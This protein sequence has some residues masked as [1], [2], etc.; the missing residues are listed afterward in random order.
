MNGDF[1]AAAVVILIGACFLGMAFYILDSGGL[2]QDDSLDMEYEDYRPVTKPILGTNGPI[3]LVT[4]DGTEYIHA[5]GLGSCTVLYQG[6][7]KDTFTV[8][9]AAAN[10]ILMCGQSNAAYHAANPSA[11]LAPAIGT[12]F[13][14]GNEDGMSET[15]ADDVSNFKFYDFIDCEGALRVGDKGPAFAAT[16]YQETGHKAIWIS[17]GMSGRAVSFWN[18]GAAAWNKDLEIMTLANQLLPE[19]FDITGTYLFWSQGETDYAY[20]TGMQHYISTWTSFHDRAP[21]AWGRDIDH[22]YLAMGRYE[23]CGWVNDAFETLASTLDDVSIG[24]AIAE[25]FTIDNTLLRGDSLHYS[26]QGDNALAVSLARSCASDQ[27]YS[28]TSAP[29]YLMETIIRC[30]VNDTV[31]LDDVVSCRTVDNRTLKL[32][33]EWAS[34]PVTTTAGIYKITGTTDSTMMI[35]GTPSPIAMLYVGYIGYVDG[36]E[37]CLNADGGASVIGRQY[38]LENAIIPETVEGVNVTE[39]G[40]FALYRGPFLKISIPDTVTTLG[41]RSLHSTPLVQE[42]YL[43]DGIQT[44]D[45]NAITTHLYDNGTELTQTEWRADPSILY[46]TWKWDGTNPNHLY[47]V[48]TP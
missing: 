18:E 35:E 11:A 5:T 33:A 36:I 12:G 21:G 2:D 7:G 29:V 34:S 41:E 25:T 17:L 10:L 45:W 37:Y 6:G 23:T 1:V 22:W 20:D 19:G 48:V 24:S 40:D 42:M 28:L 9:K 13:Y 43:G 14:F 4:V 47:K 16:W 15:T 8:K 38:T 3:E 30:D 46:G 44:I 31:S 39:I 32:E 26:Q 27:G